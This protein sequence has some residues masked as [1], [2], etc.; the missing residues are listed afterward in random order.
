MEPPKRTDVPVVSI[1]EWHQRLGHL[2]LV[3][4]RH[5]LNA[6]GIRFSEKNTEQPC[7]ACAIGK[8]KNAQ[9]RGV[10]ANR[11]T[12]PLGRVCFDLSGRMRTPSL[13]KAEYF[14]V[15][16]DQATGFIE[17]IFVKTK[18][19]FGDGLI[20]WFEYAQKQSGHTLLIIRCDNAGEHIKVFKHC[21][22]HQVKVETTIAGNSNQNGLAERMI[23]EME[24]KGRTMIVQAAA[25][26]SFWAFA[27]WLA[28]HL[29]NSSSHKRTNWVPPAK[30]MFNEPQRL[31]LIK[32]FGC[33]VYVKIEGASKLGAQAIIGAYLGPATAVNKRG[34][35]VWLPTEH[36]VAN[37][38]HYN[39]DE[40]HFAWVEANKPGNLRHLLSAFEKTSE[41]ENDEEKKELQPRVT[42]TVNAIEPP[43]VVI[44]PEQQVTES[45]APA[46]GGV[47]GESKS[48]EKPASIVRP[49]HEHLD[50][51]HSSS[52]NVQS[53][54]VE[55]GCGDVRNPQPAVSD[56]H[57]DGTS[58]TNA[59]GGSP[60]HQPSQHT[61]TST[62]R[63]TLRER[64]G[65]PALQYEPDDWRQKQLLLDEYQASESG[66]PM[67]MLAQADEQDE[68]LVPLTH[69]QAMSSAHAKE[70]RAAELEELKSLQ[71]KKTYVV[72][73]PPPHVK[74][75]KSKI[76]YAEKTN[77]EGVVTRRKARIVAGGYGQQYMRDYTQT[78]ADVAPIRDFRIVL[79]IAVLKK[80]I[81]TQL[82][83]KSAFLNSDLKEEVWMKVP[84]GLGVGFWK[85]LKALYGLR[86]AANEW[87]EL[88]DKVM[89]ALG[90]M[91]T[92]ADPGFYFKREGDEIIL[93]VVHVDD[94]LIAT[95]T[96]KQR[97]W[98]IEKL[99]Q[100]WEIKV[101]LN[102]TWLLRMKITQDPETGSI[103]LD[104]SAYLREVIKRFGVPEGK[105]SRV[106]MQPG[107]Y[108][109]A[110]GENETSDLPDDMKSLY[111]AIIGSCMYAATQTRPDI[112]YPVSHLSKFLHNPTSLHMN[113]ANRLL[114]YLNS[115]I[116]V[117]LIYTSKDSTKSVHE[118]LKPEGW[119]DANFA[120]DEDRHSIE[121]NV[122]CVE[123][124]LVS[125]LS[126]RIKNVCLS[127]EEAELTSTSEA[128]RE[129]IAIRSIL[130]QIGVMKKDTAI[131]LYC[132]NSPA[133]TAI[134]NP[135]YYGRLKHLDVNHKFAM[136]ANKSGIVKVKW[137]STS[138]MFADALTKP[139]PACQLD[140][141][142][143]V[144]MKGNTTVFSTKVP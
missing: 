105:T 83:V 10:S 133:V 102:P 80:L 107:V 6:S 47:P 57:V 109:R 120:N 23:Q 114:Q 7:D 77:E 30:A 41:S 29:Y 4:L 60:T 74:P 12:K 141:F 81:I 85:L 142:K 32:P 89:K 21:E 79:A 70:W 144:V 124:N 53:V 45:K 119:C 82:D 117:G 34:V 84:D 28:C 71:D 39:C 99:K 26:P 37:V 25:P 27:I 121:A 36:R 51:K 138:D 35:R 63:Y 136:E 38:L 126:K 19:Q 24:V 54:P 43:K 11:A 93:L 90:L 31:E 52:N 139:L 16:V 62:S 69:E 97:D 134:N 101:E 86:Q 65:V 128:A 49:D 118:Y 75:L 87:R 50:E 98:L 130:Q 88:V 111:Q 17:V 3:E 56:C 8:M 55:L 122:F 91:P 116:D 2:G 100:H 73:V 137:I 58:A 1:N 108:L 48:A 9:L 125:W 64:R 140:K 68:S 96:T 18:D 67:I 131:T 135:G 33:V 106:P 59:S 127:T 95:T 40:N 113:A 103:K 22:E 72:G 110:C 66:K 5:T 129:A 46:S 42:S 112:S 123:D 104:Q 20:K 78:K 92:N 115:S 61:E 143:K 15:A 94:M 44:Q 76:V 13:G 132:D 14:G